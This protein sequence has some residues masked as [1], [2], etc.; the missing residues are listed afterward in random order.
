[1]YSNVPAEI[2]RFFLADADFLALVVYSHVGRQARGIVQAEMGMRVNRLL[3]DFFEWHL[4]EELWAALD[5][6]RGGITGSAPLWVMEARPEW[7]VH[8]LNMVVGWGRADRARCF[9]DTAGWTE[10]SPTRRVPMV[11]DRHSWFT[12]PAHEESSRYTDRTWRYDALNRPA[13]TLTETADR[14]V[15]RHLAGARSTLASSLLTH[16][17]LIS[18]HGFECAR[19]ICVWRGGEDTDHPQ[20]EWVF[21]RVFMDIGA[22]GEYY[23][24]QGGYPCGKRCVGLLRRL[25]GGTA[26][27]LLAWK[28]S[29][30]PSVAA[31]RP[32]ES[33]G[34]SSDVL[35]WD[36]YAG[37][38]GSEY[39]FGWTWAQCENP[40]CSTFLF[41]RDMV[42]EAPE[43]R[44]ARSS[45]DM[46]IL[47]IRG[48]ILNCKPRYP[49]L[50]AGMLFATS[51][52]QARVVPVA[53][54]HG[55]DTYRTLDDLCTRAWITPRIVGMPPSSMFLPPG[56]LV[57]GTSI[58]SPLAWKEELSQ[59]KYL[60]II[61]AS[62]QPVGPV[63]DLLTASADPRAVH[64]DV[65]LMLENDGVLQHL[66]EAD[67]TKMVKWFQRCEKQLPIYAFV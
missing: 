10:G 15:F 26:V 25:R 64:G 33:A 14:A 21:D 1:M 65:L 35:A 48:A 24:G 54:D 8:D 12:L 52:P 22:T 18:L 28:P 3:L 41:P 51:C 40:A 13:I 39:A 31:P 57:G 63:N 53:L 17:C 34:R 56:L 62:V 59:G 23:D 2:E 5:Y 38:P 6:G 61:A 43:G 58:F 42:A 7:R 32:K 11:K 55:I 60:L 29:E 20:Y 9:L 19:K 27:G 37:F 67:A 50:H 45:K 47:R 4:L 66:E 44:N 46:R 36:A 16:S 30:L 49:V